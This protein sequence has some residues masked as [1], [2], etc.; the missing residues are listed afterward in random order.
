V[1]IEHEREL[2]SRA[3]HDPTAF[4]ELYRHYFPRIYGYVAYRVEH[5]PDAEDVVADVFV[6][7]VA[8][9]HGFTYRGDGSL[10]AWLFRIARNAVG[11]YYRQRLSVSLDSLP[12]LSSSDP[13][14]E[15]LL[16]EKEE[17]AAMRQLLKKLPL[18]RQ[19]VI[20][21]RYYGDLRNQEIAAVL[22]LDEHTIASHLSR[23][24]ADLREQLQLLKRGIPE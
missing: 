11:S 2:V 6:K 9:L 12:D 18:R 17:A 7:M 14:P 16:M 22:G 21:L 5:P 19:E 13:P 10:A 8:G 3:G 24:L 15:G 23:G 4:R 1:E 20:I